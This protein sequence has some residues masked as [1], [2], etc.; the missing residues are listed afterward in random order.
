MILQS[1]TGFFSGI[2]WVFL[3]AWWLIVPITLSGMLFKAW[4][5]IRQNQFLASIEW[6][7]LVINIPKYNLRSPF[8]AEQMIIGFWGM[9]HSINVVDK[10]W[11]GA[12][13]EYLSLEIAS[14]GGEVRFII[15][16]PVPLRNL[17]ESQVYAQYPDAEITQIED[18]V[19]FT[20]YDVTKGDYDLWGSDLI[21]VNEEAYPIRTYVGFEKGSTAEEEKIVDPIAGIISA[22]SN[23]GPDERMWFQILIQPIDNLWK[24]AGD[25]IVKKLIGAKAEEKP[26]NP[27]IAIFKP[28]IDEFTDMGRRLI[29][30]PFQLPEDM[31][32]TEDKSR[33]KE[34]PSLMQYLSPGETDI[35]AAVQSKT[36]KAGFNTKM[37]FIYIGKKEVFSKAHVGAFMGALNQYSS[38]NLN[39]IKPYAPTKT[40]ADYYLTKYRLNIKKAKVLK[41]YKIRDLS[42]PSYVLNIEELASLF[43]VPESSVKVPGV[44]ETKAR[45]SEPPMDLPVVG[46]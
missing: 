1:I 10:Y 18:Y 40:A 42:L 38:Q 22:M 16:T 24:E 12:L 25:K 29:Q 17:V 5:K 30:A 14:M 11:H 9:I 39:A 4:L 31:P 19:D 34:L 2:A 8:F 37:R 27:I 13:Q 44:V 35:V 15:R 28:I 7:N 45:K 23:I 36:S 33:L 26:T 46:S 20:T 21:L 41:A 6:V 32:S 3:K 43:H